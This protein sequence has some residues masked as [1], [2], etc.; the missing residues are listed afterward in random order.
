MYCKYLVNNKI[1][2]FSG[3]ICRRITESRFF[4][5]PLV[6]KRSLHRAA[7]REQGAPSFRVYGHTSSAGGRSRPHAL[8]LS[9]LDVNPTNVFINKIVDRADSYV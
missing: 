4:C 3:F 9:L 7:V 5:A 6:A 2:P 1:N 8:S